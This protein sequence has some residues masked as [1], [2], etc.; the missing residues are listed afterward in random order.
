[1]CMTNGRKH[2]AQ[3]PNVE[4]SSTPSPQALPSPSPLSTL[5][6][7]TKEY[8]SNSV[9]QSSLSAGPSPRP[10]ALPGSTTSIL[11]DHS[12][13]ESMS[14]SSTSSLDTASPTVALNNSAT[15]Q[16]TKPI[17]VGS[18]LAAILAVALIIAVVTWFI[19]VRSRRK[20][21]DELSWDPEPN[22]SHSY[23]SDSF[24]NS[25]SSSQA[26]RDRITLSVRPQPPDPATRLQPDLVE[27]PAIQFPYPH[28]PTPEMAHTVGPLTVTN[29]MPGDVPL[30]TNTSI[31]MASRPGST[32]VTPQINHS[33]PRFTRLPGGGLPVP[34]SRGAPEQIKGPS[35]RPRAWPS[36]LSAASLKNVFSSSA[37][38]PTQIDPPQPRTSA[39]NMRTYFRLN[40]NSDVQ[41]PEPA[42]AADPTWPGTIR[43]GITNAWSTVMGTTVRPLEQPDNNLT[44]IRPRPNRRLSSKTGISTLD[45]MSTTSTQSVAGYP[46]EEKTQGRPIVGGFSYM[47]SHEMP[48]FDKTIKEEE[49]E[50]ESCTDSSSFA[51]CSTLKNTPAHTVIVEQ[52]L[53]P[54][55]PRVLDD[56]VGR[57]SSVP[58]LPT[59]RPLSRAWTLRSEGFITLPESGDGYRSAFDQMINERKQ[60]YERRLA[61]LEA[62]A[63]E[64]AS[65]PVMSRASTTLSLMTESTALSRESSFMDDE[66]RRAKKVLRM[67]RKRAM[68][69]S[70]SAIGNGKVSGS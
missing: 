28:L 57:P 38:K 49:A 55:I 16:N 58:M 36:R 9:P 50:E 41:L 7:E 4:R 33:A 8:S 44:P 15:N 26:N 27:Q 61:E 1:M 52:P 23:D 37:P 3:Q 42:K 6:Q 62:V 12:L 18:I 31:F 48:S 39:A 29:L 47:L 17:I 69:L 53:V 68:A 34:W 25:P 43:A 35:S 14:P 54:Q 66:E 19:R 11:S 30:S 32:Q 21:Q 13:V 65:R 51:G 10:T 67:R 46:M 22:S 70:A 59:I 63:A 40:S 20:S 64:E 5:L 60:E 24:L 2:Q 56:V 45:S